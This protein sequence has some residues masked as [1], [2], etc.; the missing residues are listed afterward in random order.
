MMEL[1]YIQMVTTIALGMLI[2]HVK[3]G[4][5]ALVA[6]ALKPAAA[7]IMEIIKEHANTTLAV[8]ARATGQEAVVPDFQK[9]TIN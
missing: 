3:G 7:L 8:W 2:T 5:P 4:A 6:V 9:F 1:I